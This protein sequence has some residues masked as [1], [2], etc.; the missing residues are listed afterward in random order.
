MR[1]K[2]FNLAAAL[3]LLLCVAVC[4]LW[5]RGYGLTDQ[6]V[7]NRADGVRSIGSSRGRVVLALHVSKRARVSPY[8]YGF[9]H[10]RDKSSPANFASVHV[11]IDRGSTYADWKGGG[12]EW[13]MYRPRADDYLIARAVAP[14]WFF[15]TAAAILP[16]VW[17]GLKVRAR[18]RN[19]RRERL[20]LCRTCGYDLRGTPKGGRCPECG[21]VSRGAAKPPHNPPMERTAAAV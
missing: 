9:H 16:L 12:F 8:G 7:W 2:L 21:C 13:Y 10:S 4:V 11:S 5:A 6:I 14:H 17:S 1:R 15:A 20:G 3:S 19:D 18:V